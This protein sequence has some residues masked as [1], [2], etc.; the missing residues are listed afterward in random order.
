MT[1]ENKFDEYKPQARQDGGQTGRLLI[2]L[3]VFGLLGAFFFMQFV[4]GVRGLFGGGALYL[5]VR[6]AWFALPAALLVF[7]F[8]K[9]RPVRRS[10]GGSAVTQ[11]ALL[12]L[13]WAFVLGGAV[14]W[15]LN[16]KSGLEIMSEEMDTQ[17]QAC[18][19]HVASV[20][21]VGVVSD[22]HEPGDG[23][24][25]LKASFLADTRLTVSGGGWLESDMPGLNFHSEMQR[26]DLEPGVRRVLE[27]HLV[28]NPDYSN[29]PKLM[30]DGPYSFRSIPVYVMDPVKAP[31]WNAI[32]HDCKADVIS[33][34]VTSQAY[35]AADFGR[36]PWTG[37]SDSSFKQKPPA[38]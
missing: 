34:F 18:R 22:S 36:E 25:T 1:D 38:R 4:F 14:V 16:W 33:G 31:E 7:A 12:A 21:Q 6:L 20:L 3:A 29:I 27:I 19:K 26:A 5:I 28:S 37:G 30:V 24:I 8:R 35:K 9:F 17:R 2:F 15:R 13:A 10:F 23:Y 11:F 32:G